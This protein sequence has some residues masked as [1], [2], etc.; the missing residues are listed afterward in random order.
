MF[1]RDHRAAI[2]RVHWYLAYKMQAEAEQAA[3]SGRLSEGHLKDIIRSHLDLKAGSP[4]VD[5]FFHGIRERVGALV[6]RVVGTFEFEVQPLRE[7]F[8]A[9]FLHD[10]AAYS[11]VGGERRGAL[12]DRF[13]A[14]AVNPY[15]LNVTRFYAGCYSSGEL[16]SLVDG[17]EMLEADDFRRYS[18]HLLWLSL[19]LLL[20]NVFDQQ[21]RLANSIANRVLTQPGLSILFSQQLMGHGSYQEIA[22]PE[23]L[24]K[25]TLVAECVAKLNKKASYETYQ[26]FTRTL[27]A[28]A[29]AT[30]LYDIWISLPVEE[31][32]VQSWCM[33]GEMLSAFELISFQNAFTCLERYGAAF[34]AS[35]IDKKRFY[36]VAEYHGSLDL[37]VNSVFN[38]S[39]RTTF[40]S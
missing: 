7:Y 13:A 18:A 17:L 2:E 10:T 36:V 20:D 15:W 26:V 6:S 23:R 30:E 19:V 33:I 28:N 8:A 1:F 34:L 35:L 14:I 16:A 37:V 40:S 5:E 11:P 3:G 29:T 38:C 24:G 9:R 39:E 22:L 12:P 25:S 31:I 4:E 21:P 27:V 32:G